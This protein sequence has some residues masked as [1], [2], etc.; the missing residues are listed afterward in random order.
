MRKISKDS[1]IAPLSYLA[2]L[3]SSYYY[4]AAAAASGL[5]CWLSRVAKASPSPLAHDIYISNGAWR[6]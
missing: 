2:S 4:A 3:V 5:C 1:K 6:T